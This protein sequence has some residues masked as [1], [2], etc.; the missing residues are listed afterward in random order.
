MAREEFLDHLR[1]AS[2]TLPPPTGRT[3]KGVSADADLASTFHNGNH[4]LT[5]TAV[6]GFDSADFHDLTQ[7]ERDELSREV[8]A[9]LA[10]AGQVSAG[11]PATKAQSNQCRKHLERVIE[12]VGRRVLS[13]WLEAQ[14]KMLDEATAA[15]KAKGWYVEQDEKQLLESLLGQYAAPRLRIRTPNNEVVLDPI[16]RFGGGRQGVVD[17]VAMPTYETMYLVTYKNGD[18][19]IVAPHGTL[20]R[21]PFTQATLVNT[22]THLSQR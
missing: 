17:L 6:E 15:A 1:A 21:R 14:R 11:K 5:P 4:W 10:V 7:K 8:S 22:I 3:G 12:I 13:E 20:H 16:A 2:R 18:W 19:Q 9:F